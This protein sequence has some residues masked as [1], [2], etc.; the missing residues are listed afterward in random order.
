M[1]KT[2]KKRG[3]KLEITTDVTKEVSVPELLLHRQEILAGIAHYE[4]AL[5]EV[6]FNLAKAAE[7]G[8]DT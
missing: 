4:S 6:D 8:V 1:A 2:Y 7:L 5:A 3:A